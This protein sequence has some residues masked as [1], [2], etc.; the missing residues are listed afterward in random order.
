[1]IIN[2]IHLQKPQ[3]IPCH[4]AFKFGLQHW[5][6]SLLSFSCLRMLGRASPQ[7][8]FLLLILLFIIAL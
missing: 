2:M 3:C 4:F 1:M 5:C 8:H 6:F 7:F